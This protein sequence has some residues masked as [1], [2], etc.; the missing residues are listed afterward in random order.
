MPATQF[1]KRILPG[2]HTRITRRRQLAVDGG[3][4]AAT[5]NFVGQ[6]LPEPIADAHV[7][8]GLG[9]GG[10]GAPRTRGKELARQRRCIR[11]G[12]RASWQRR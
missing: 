8:L 4:R 6:R 5:Q 3:G 2:D 12:P 7:S 1:G 11:G 9:R 10:L